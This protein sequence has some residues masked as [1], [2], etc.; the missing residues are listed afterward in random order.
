VGRKRLRWL[1]AGARDVHGQEA[2]ST[3]ADTL[4]RDAVER[5][6]LAALE[7]HYGRRAERRSTDHSEKPVRWN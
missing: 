2:L 1:R 7:D 4:Q 3:I 5:T 6:S